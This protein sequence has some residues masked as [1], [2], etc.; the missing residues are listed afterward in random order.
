MVLR[1]LNASHI[2]ILALCHSYPIVKFHLSKIS[3]IGRV[4]VAAAAEGG[5]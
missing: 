4:E 3:F 2:K 1:I 5:R